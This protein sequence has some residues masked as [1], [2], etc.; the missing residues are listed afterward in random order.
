MTDDDERFWREMARMP[1]LQKLVERAGRR[2]AASHRGSL[3]GKPVQATS[4][5]GR[6]SAHHSRGMGEMGCRQRRI[7]SQPTIETVRTG[8]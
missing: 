1:D 6:L 2:Y 3:C 5:S 4:P 7:P 8:P